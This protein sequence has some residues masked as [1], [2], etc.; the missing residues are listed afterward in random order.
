MHADKSVGKRPLAVLNASPNPIEGIIEKHAKF[1]EQGPQAASEHVAAAGK[2]LRQASAELS[3]SF[4]P[5]G[6][7]WDAVRLG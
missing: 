3:Q 6:T 4:K 5:K 7:D 2:L 1:V